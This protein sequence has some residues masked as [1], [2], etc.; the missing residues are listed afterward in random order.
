MHRFENTIRMFCFLFASFIFVTVLADSDIFDLVHKDYDFVIRISKGGSW[1]SE[2]QKVPFFSFVLNRKG[3]GFEDSFLRI[4]EDMRYKTGVA[5]SVV[6][7]AISNDVL[8]ASK[9]IAID[10]SNV[11]SFDLNYYFDFIKTIT[12]NSFI[13]FQTKLPAQ[14]VKA[15]S[16]LL[17]VKYRVLPNN[18]YVLGDSL[19]CGSIGKYLVVAGSKQ[20]LELALKTFLTPDMQMS[21]S[22]KV[23][24]RLKTGTF[25][26]SGYSKP[27]V[28]KFTFP[29]VSQLNMSD[30]EYIIFYS[31]VSAGNMSMTFEQKN[32]KEISTKK[33]SESIGNIPLAWNYYLSI[34]STNS[35]EIVNTL[36]QWFQG[37]SVDLSR[38]LEFVSAL[39]KVSSNV[40]TV[41][42]IE[43]NDFL[44]IF[45][46]ITLKDLEN[47]ISRLGARYDSQK[48]EWT[49]L[50]Q[51][52]KLS[53][54]ANSN[55][56]YFGTIDRAKYEQYER[57]R[58]KLKD[59]PLY[60]D[61]SK[62]NVY[63]FKLF[64]DIGDIIKTTTGFNI[65]SKML[66]WKYNSGYFS[67]YKILIS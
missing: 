28:I 53:I 35:E 59:L 39:S 43:T 57:T 9:G 2:I 55:R 23:F 21:K 36:K 67:Y 38:L 54:Y 51:T 18:Q 4:L 32:R 30:S 49:V 63:D 26:I 19:Y 56:V 37:S 66:F 3:L 16:F 13:A 61:F 15:L 11:I 7:E 40:Y 34:P 8:F 60:F 46:N 22:T 24:D 52:N 50:F 20:A 12:S 17:S 42:R 64:L 14:L 1:Y 5:P 62:I 65:S 10:F 58:G 48:Q 6:Q 33:V 44:F 45:D 31:S 27:D 47:S 25:F 29:G 41:G